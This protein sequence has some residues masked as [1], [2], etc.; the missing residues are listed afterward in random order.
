MERSLFHPFQPWKPLIW[1]L[2]GPCQRFQ[3]L[4]G[5]L[6]LRREAWQKH[7]TWD[8]GI[9]DDDDDDD[10][11]DYDYDDDDDDDE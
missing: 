9:D 7:R 2:P 8:I 6:E 5:Q 3:G 4:L 11:D 1:A 10:D